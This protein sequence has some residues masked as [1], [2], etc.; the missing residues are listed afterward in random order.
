M[1]DAR[2]SWWKRKKRSS[3]NTGLPAVKPGSIWPSARISLLSMM[4]SVRKMPIE[5]NR[6]NRNDKMPIRASE[7]FSGVRTGTLFAFEKWKTGGNCMFSEK[8]SAERTA[9]TQLCQEG[10]GKLPNKHMR[11]ES[12]NGRAG[13]PRHCLRGSWLKKISWVVKEQAQ[14]LTKNIF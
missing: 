6:K 1:P 5:R 8:R 10:L 7:I 4:R 2:E 13:C 3:E 11:A 14:Y 9:T 12:R